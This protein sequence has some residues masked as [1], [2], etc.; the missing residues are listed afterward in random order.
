MSGAPFLLFA[1]LGVAAWGWALVHLLIVRRKV[2]A[3]SR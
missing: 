3:C 2:D 1:L